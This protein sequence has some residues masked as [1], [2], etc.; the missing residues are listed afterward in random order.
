MIDW[1]SLEAVLN[2]YVEVNKLEIKHSEIKAQEM[3]KA[4]FEVEAAGVRKQ[5]EVY[6][7]YGAKL[8]NLKKLL[9]KK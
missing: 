1:E 9:S 2:F 5:T 6:K 3:E 4:G 7:I 8:N